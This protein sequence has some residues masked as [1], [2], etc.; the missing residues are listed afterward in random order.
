MSTAEHDCERDM[1]DHCD[2]CVDWIW[3]PERKAWGP[4]EASPYYRAIDVWRTLVDLLFAISRAAEAQAAR[5]QE[6]SSV[7]VYLN[8]FAE[9]YADMPHDSG[10]AE[11]YAIDKLVQDIEKGKHVGAW[12]AGREGAGS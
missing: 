6:R 8:A 10:G 12:A 5:E 11:S 2:R 9:A 3:C 4:R 7:V 1:Q